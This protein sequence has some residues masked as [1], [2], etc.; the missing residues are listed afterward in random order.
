MRRQ[1]VLRI[2]VMITIIGM[3]IHWLPMSYQGGL[4]ESQERRE[5]RRMGM[6]ILL[7]KCVKASDDNKRGSLI[8]VI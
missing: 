4:N 6:I 3:M 7:L 1:G 8:I 2:V 5:Q